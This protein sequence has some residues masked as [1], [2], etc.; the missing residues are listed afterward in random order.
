MVVLEQDSLDFL[1]QVTQ[2]LVAQPDPAL[3]ISELLGLVKAHLSTEAASIFVNDVA[4]DMLELRYADSPVSEEILGFRISSGQGVVGW[5]VQ[6]N[7]PLIVPLPNLD[8]RFFSGVDLRTGF[9]TRSILCVPIVRDGQVEG[10][11]EAINKTTGHFDG[12]DLALLQEVARVL[13]T[14]GPAL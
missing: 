4:E 11:I 13:V 3:A 1:A 12:D 14:F 5:V 6:Y 8:P 7:E 10:A 2:A 9:Y